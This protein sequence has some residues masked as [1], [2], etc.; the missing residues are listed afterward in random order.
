M[1]GHFGYGPMIR[2]A[3]MV[4]AH[5]RADEDF[6]LGFV[7]KPWRFHESP[8]LFQYQVMVIHDLEGIL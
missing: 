5:G 4:K 1:H 7:K 2:P 3:A 6:P 8:E